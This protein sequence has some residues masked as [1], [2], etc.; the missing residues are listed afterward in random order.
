MSQQSTITITQEQADFFREEGYLAV[1]RI[2][3]DEEVVRMRGAYDEI[4]ARRAGREEGMEYDVASADEEDT[5]PTL[6]QILE[7][8]N[9]AEA[10]RD[11][12]YETNALAISRQLLGPGC[13]YVGAFALL[14]PARIGSATPWH[15]DTAYWDP[16]L[17]DL[18]S[19]LS[20]WMPL[21]PATVENGCLYY[22]PGSHRAEVAPH[23]HVNDDPKIHA[24]E[25]DEGYFDL[26]T[27]VACPLPAGGATFHGGRICHYAP[28]NTTEEP[29]RAL[30]L[31][32]RVTKPPL[33]PAR[34]FYWQHQ[35][36]TYAAKKRGA[37]RP[38][39]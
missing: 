8:G 32:F 29:R 27:S 39:L 22:I 38:G 34:D 9:Y 18:E 23:H 16:A 31:A 13:V 28:P 21:Q 19:N 15:Q 35:T 10:L 20:V 26:S 24:L 33:E 2:T 12:R 30:V 11:S 1:E 4:F 37:T 36:D 14:K 17:D 25:L 7:P 6:V 5:E 3:T